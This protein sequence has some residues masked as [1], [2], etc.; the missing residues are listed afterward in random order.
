MFSLKKR[1]LKAD[2]ITMSEELSQEKGVHSF[3]AV[4]KIGQESINGTLII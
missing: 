1:R 4:P 2:M 3:S